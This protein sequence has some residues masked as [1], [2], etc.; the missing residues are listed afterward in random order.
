MTFLDL[1]PQLIDGALTVLSF[2][3]CVVVW[4]RTG[5]TPEKLDAKRRKRHIAALRR[6]QKAVEQLAKF[7]NVEVRFNAADKCD[8]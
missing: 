7:E 3:A 4:F 5:K 6:T 2:F 8:Q 1:L